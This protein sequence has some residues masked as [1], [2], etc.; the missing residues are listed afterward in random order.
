MLRRK[1]FLQ[2]ALFVCLVV[3]S[4][5]IGVSLGW[6]GYVFGGDP[7]HV[8]TITLCVFV[9][10]TI[11]CGRLCWRTEKGDDPKTIR[12]SLASGWFASSVCVTLGLLGT[13]IGYFIMMQNVSGG[14]EGAAEQLVSQI[15][16]GLGTVL[17]NT[18]VG[19]VCGLLIEVQSHFIGQALEERTDAEKDGAP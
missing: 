11:W 12:R 6:T 18:I 16:L 13:V 7:T 9:F 2:W 3:I 1:L 15:R 14:A 8:T 5:S 17:I 19:G 4:A 10:T